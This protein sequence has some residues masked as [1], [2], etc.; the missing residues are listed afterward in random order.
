MATPIYRL[1]ILTDG[2]VFVQ[3]VW[4]QSQ[5]RQRYGNLILTFVRT[6]GPTNNTIFMEFSSVRMNF[7][8]EIFIKI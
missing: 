4:F 3:R 5:N 1:Q 6:F 7:K 8:M 2:M